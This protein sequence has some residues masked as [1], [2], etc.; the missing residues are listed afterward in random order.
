MFKLFLALFILLTAVSISAQGVAKRIIH[1]DPSRYRSLQAVHA[2]A[3]KMQFTELI[4]RQAL[5]TNFL[6]LHAGVIEPKS[7]IGHHFHHSIEEMYVLLSGEAEFTINGHTSKIKAPAIVP[8]KLGDAHAIYNT[9]G[10]AVKWLNFAVSEV[11]GKAENFDLGD[12]REGASL[13]PIPVFVSS[14]L[15]KEGLRPNN[16]AFRGALYKR[17]F[18][19]D[20]FGTN[21]NNVDHM[22]IPAGVSA[23][24][25]RETGVEDVYY[26]MSGSATIVINND[27][28]NIN[29]DDAF[30]V[31][32][33]ESLTINNRGNSDLDL[34]VIGVAINK[35][36][37]QTPAA[38][39]PTAMVLQMDFIV[40]RSDSA[41]FENVYHTIYVPGMRAQKGY[42]GSKLLRLYPE[43]LAKEIQAEPTTYNY[44]VQISFDTEENRRKWVASSE[45]QIAWP[46]ATKTGK[47]YKWRGY[48]VMGADEVR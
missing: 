45:H 14:Q 20:I 46:A 37:G 2:G 29:T 34:L 7:S 32:V 1:N 4:G 16:P 48:T 36:K 38:A 43:A 35:N 6:Y 21:W 40:A 10:A 28:A 5:A 18:G 41:A 3:G 27:S 31:S 11:K 13:D 23:K 42:L 44:Q 26:V 8:C 24:P 15:K 9:T 25:T 33:G 22:V 19:P 17:E 39:K 30:P 12:T 47:V